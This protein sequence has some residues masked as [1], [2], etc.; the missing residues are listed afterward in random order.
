M[1]R[2]FEWI[3]GY[4]IV[5]VPERAGAKF[6]NI[7]SRFGVEYHALGEHGGRLLFRLHLFAS[8]RVRTLCKK[9]RIDIRVERRRGFPSLAFSLVRR[10]GLCLGMAICALM[11]VFSSHTVWDVRIEGNKYVSEAVIKDTLRECGVYVGSDKRSLDIDAIQNRF[12]ILSDDISWISVNMV[13]GVAEVEVREVQGAS[14]SPDYICSNLIA[15]QNGTVVEFFEVKGNIS[16]K[17]GEEVQ[18]GQLLVSGA[19]GD[20]SSATR[21]VRS[22]GEVRALCERDYEIR[23]PLS[24]EK[25]VPTGNKKIKKSLIFFEKEVK[26]FI[27][28]RNLYTSCDIIEGEEYLNPFGLGALPVGVRTVTYV[29]YVTKSGVRSEE[30][31]REQAIYELWQ[32]FYGD[33]PHGQVVSKSFVGEIVG[34]EYILRATVGSIENIASEQEVEINIVGVDCGKIYEDGKNRGKRYNSETFRQL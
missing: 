12:L 5:S 32:R 14:P 25:K 20:D 23:V 26:L 29:E 15:T 8:L 19:Y 33:S 18:K 6:I 28:S 3:V 10:P 11:L 9:A 2:P 21:F 31:A 13:G 30:Q 4:D 27:N 34:E 7:C 24:F 16:V 22:R 1:Y 17:L